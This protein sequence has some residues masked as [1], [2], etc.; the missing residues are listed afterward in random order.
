[1][2][3][4]LLSQK[5]EKDFARLPQKEKRK[6]VKKLELLQSEPLSGKLLGGKLKGLWSLRAWPYRIIYEFHHQ[7]III[8]RILHRQ[9]AYK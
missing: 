2:P 7:K 4:V 3:P 8:L 6:I 9:K 1:M 5:A